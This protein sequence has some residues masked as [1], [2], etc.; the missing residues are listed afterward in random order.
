MR[1]FGWLALAALAGALVGFGLTTL[2]PLGGPLWH[3]NAAFVGLAA[4]GLAAWRL[5]PRR[6]FATLLLAYSGILATITGFV[7]L[8]S[9]D[10]PYKEHVTWWHS[11]TSF[12]LLGAFL[13]H[14]WRN[15]PRLAGFTRRLAARLPVGGPAAGA[16]T[17]GLA[18]GALTWTSAWRPRFT[19]ENYLYLSSWAVLV[20]VAFTYGLWLW[21]R[22]PSRRARLA[23]P[24]Y[25]ATARALV[26]TSL[27]AACWLAL[28]TGFALL[29]F[30]DFLRSG[31]TKYV[32]KWWHT[33][34]SVAFLAFVAIHVGFNARPL[35]AHAK[36]V[37]GELGGPRH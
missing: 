7:M 9:K 17:A 15:Q 26:D 31:D 29:Y 37:D 23:D 8:Y 16:W 35:A 21:H 20:G 33:A 14:W 27:F 6:R 24:A 18:V 3:Y 32:S 2:V 19:S 13:A 1:R 12:A 5:L 11:V 4:A 34:T 30:R 28:L 22:L 25:R 10:L 36:R